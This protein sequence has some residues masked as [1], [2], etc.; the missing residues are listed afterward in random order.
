MDKAQK[1]IDPKSL[2]KVVLLLGGRSSEREVSLMSGK[3]VFDALQGAGVD[4]TRFDPQEQPLSELEKGDYD[5]AVISLHGRFGEDG[6]IQGVLEY[7]N[8]PYTGPGVRASAIAI[9]KNLTKLVWRERQIP[10]PNGMLVTKDSD[11][12]FVIQELGV[13]LVV[14][15]SREGSSI[16]LTKLEYANVQT[17]REAVEK[18]SQLDPQVLVEERIYGRELT[19]AIL[20]EGQ[21]ARVLPIIE[22]VAPDG[23]YD[24]QNKYFTD[25][26][27]YECPADLSEELRDDIS[28]TCLRAYRAL[29]ARGWSRIDVML[30]EDGRFV[31]LE[32][33]T[34][35]GM[36]AHSLVPL[37]AKNAGMSYEELVL[38]V[39][40]SASL[41]TADR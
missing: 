8:I 16:G 10:T 5:R 26:V 39:A 12:S 37:T 21:D 4:V 18:A 2:G 40:A 11:M 13:N 14:K 28:T 29:G 33:N 22:I 6:T 19:V 3:G 24:Y 9:D 15:P 31:L 30:A 35:P 17:L 25:V 41:D 23:D 34:S 38:Q 1:S 27:R 36:T 32:M 7:L 20:G